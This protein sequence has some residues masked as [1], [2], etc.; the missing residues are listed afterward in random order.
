MYTLDGGKTWSISNVSAPGQKTGAYSY[1][2]GEGLNATIYRRMPFHCLIGHRNF[3]DLISLQSIS[4]IQHIDYGVKIGCER[5]FGHTAATDLHQGNVTHPE[6]PAWLIEL[7]SRPHNFWR[8]EVKLYAMIYMTREQAQMLMHS[9]H[10]AQLRKWE[11]DNLNTSI[12]EYLKVDSRTDK[13]RPQ[14]LN[15]SDVTQGSVVFEDRLQRK[16][17]YI[18]FQVDG[19]LTALMIMTLTTYD[20]IS[21]WNL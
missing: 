2:H 11:A 16:H 15:C 20:K 12:P 13:H 17:T 9:M 19:R 7:V 14:W 3:G 4:I 5:V 10:Y 6:I 8:F 1:K 21:I 18:N